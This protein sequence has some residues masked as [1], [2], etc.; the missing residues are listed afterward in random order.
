MVT[1]KAYQVVCVFIHVL[2]LFRS[3]TQSSAGILSQSEEEDTIN[4][5]VR[6]VHGHVTNMW[7][8]V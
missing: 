4:V 7:L 1:L 8:W 2:L 6:S 3:N 5:V